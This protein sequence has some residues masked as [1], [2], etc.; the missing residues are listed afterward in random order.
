[1]EGKKKPNT[2]DSTQ[3]AIDNIYE[4]RDVA[5]RNEYETTKETNDYVVPVRRS[6]VLDMKKATRYAESALINKAGP[7]GDSSKH[8]KE[9]PIRHNPDLPTEVKASDCKRSEKPPA[10]SMQAKIL[11]GIVTIFIAAAA[12]TGIVVFL[13]TRQTGRHKRQ[14]WVISLP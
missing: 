3:P 4:N 1:M 5:E 11:I 6:P 14:L 10:F 13:M 2:L 9:I 7:V 8:T 12:V